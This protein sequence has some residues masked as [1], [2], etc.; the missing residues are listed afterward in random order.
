M[1]EEQILDYVD[2]ERAASSVTVVTAQ[3]IGNTRYDPSHSTASH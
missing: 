3:A 1:S 2:A